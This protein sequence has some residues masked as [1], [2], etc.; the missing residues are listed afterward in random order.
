VSFG[1]AGWN[2]T[3]VSLDVANDPQP[4][5]QAPAVSQS[6]TYYISASIT[7]YVAPGDA[8]QCFANSAGGTEAT[9]GLASSGQYYTIPVIGWGSMGPGDVP[10]VLC[11]DLESDVGTFYVSGGMTATL[12]SNSVSAPT[13][14]HA[15]R[16][17]HA[18]LLKLPP[19]PRILPSRPHPIPASRPHHTPA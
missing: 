16:G 7:V 3:Y 5:L 2:A 12:I 8:V 14:P 19:H 10:E 1:T 4:V 9:T 17:T 11:T 13:A 6:G 15:A 18:A